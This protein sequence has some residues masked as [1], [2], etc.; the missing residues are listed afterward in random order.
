LSYEVVTAGTTYQELNV[1]VGTTASSVLNTTFLSGLTNI[2]Y[3]AAYTPTPGLNTI[4]FTTPFIWD[5]TSNLVIEFCWSN[6]NG[7]G[8][9]TT[10]KYDNTTYAAQS[11]YMADNQ[12]PSVL[13]GTTTATATQTK[14]PMFT[15]N[16]TNICS[17]PRVEVTA[18]VGASTPITISNDVTICNGAITSI[19]V[20][21]GASSY[22]EFTWTPETNLFT[23]AA[24]T[25][26]YVA[27]ASAS[28][29][30]MKTNVAGIYNLCLCSIILQLYAVQPI[31][32]ISPF[33]RPCNTHCKSS[34]ICVSGA[35]TLNVTPTTVLVQQR[36]SLPNR[37]MVLRLAIFPVQMDLTIQQV[38]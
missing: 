21:S 20:T 35:T 29:V 16:G 14:R 22:D 12:L 10:V 23:D 18:T 11:Y 34:S 37:Q 36:S 31:P 3:N 17:S 19:Q 8:T 38:F 27:G 30:Y 5:G 9:S 13:C 26:P 15:L 28:Q 1:S 33:F 25:T 32:F 4:T 6:N 24:C 7:G 2:Y